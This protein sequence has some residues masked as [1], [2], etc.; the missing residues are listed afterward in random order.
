MI[1]NKDCNFF[2]YGA[3]IEGNRIKENLTK[4]GYLVYGFLDAIKRT[5]ILD[6]NNKIFNL[7]D[8][9]ELNIYNNIVI[10][11]LADG[12]IHAQVI[13]N[14]KKIGFNYFIFIPLSMPINQKLKIDN[15]NLFNKVAYGD[16]DINEI[17][18]NHIDCLFKLD[19]DISNQTNKN[20]VFFPIELLY[21]EL[22]E[23]AMSNKKELYDNP[24]LGI[25]N[26]IYYL[27][28]N[29]NNSIFECDEYFKYKK[30]KPTLE[31][32]QNVIKS[33]YKQHLRFVKEY[34]QGIDLFVASAPH[35][36]YNKKGYFNIINGH[37]RTN[38]LLA[39]GRRDVPI[40]VNDEEFEIWKN[41]EVFENI[42][43]VFTYDVLS[44]L[45]YP[46]L[47]PYFYTHNVNTDLFSLD[48]VRH[49]YKIIS[50]LQENDVNILDNSKGYGYFAHVF[51]LSQ[52][53]KTYYYI[54]EKENIEI[55]KKIFELY[56]NTTTEFVDDLKLTK[57]D[58][59][60]SLS[61]V[62]KTKQEFMSI[63][64]N[65]NYSSIIIEIQND[66]IEEINNTNFDII[67]NRIKDDMITTIISFNK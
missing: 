7:K 46:I 9:S 50:N 62:I 22:N 33:R 41:T 5:N 53:Y 44:K 31:E 3:G 40:K 15:I 63:Y 24:F 47:N 11:G 13:N 16:C 18:I 37:H 51:S 52:K 61:K 55:T 10:I 34:N 21:I 57:F 4:N 60:I 49:V 23:N 39:Q 25:E 35:S 6:E 28:N 43:D 1:I 8:I 64:E 66:L 59:I 65:N 30:N 17:E 36:I 42:K 14:L 56:R 12:M 26:N 67:A 29:F 20:T 2:I 32:K 19:F 54:D 27:F 48:V 58:I 38:F 45:E